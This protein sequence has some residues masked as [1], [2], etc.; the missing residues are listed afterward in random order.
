MKSMSNQLSLNYMQ[1]DAITLLYLSSHICSCLKPN[2][3][4]CQVEMST[5]MIRRLLPEGLLRFC[6][7]ITLNV[8]IVKTRIMFNLCYSMSIQCNSM[9]RSADLYKTKVKLTEQ[10]II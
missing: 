9:S 3:I 7:F 8:M 10:S 1:N 5:Q 2:F 6:L 4:T